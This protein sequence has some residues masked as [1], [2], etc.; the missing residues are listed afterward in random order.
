MKN[1]SLKYAIADCLFRFILAANK[2]V[3]TRV[4]LVESMITMIRAS[5]QDEKS[6]EE[7]NK[8]LVGAI[9]TLRGQYHKAFDLSPD[10]IPDRAVFENMTYGLMNDCLVIAL[11]ENLISGSIMERRAFLES[12]K[13]RDED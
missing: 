11:K 4:N 1:D 13:D 3:S 6:F 5:L 9:E 7:D 10:D 2:S 12:P 8:A